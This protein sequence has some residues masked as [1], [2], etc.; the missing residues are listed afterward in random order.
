MAATS[1]V[2]VSRLSASA[3]HHDDA[4]TQTFGNENRPQETD[5]GIRV[6]A[7]GIRDILPS[8]P[9]TRRVSLGKDN[10]FYRPS[11]T[12]GNARTEWWCAQSSANQSLFEIPY[13]AGKIQ[14][15][16]T[17]MLVSVGVLWP[18]RAET[19]DAYREIPCTTKQGIVS[20][21]SRNYFVRT[22]LGSWGLL[23]GIDSRKGGA[24]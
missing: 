17:Q 13:S 21:A 6:S 7:A 3:N 2:A 18:N 8:V 19:S 14:G 4:S 20:L 11:E 22:G 5:V 1:R 12:Q 16:F 9:S 15:T 10:A 24:R 23:S